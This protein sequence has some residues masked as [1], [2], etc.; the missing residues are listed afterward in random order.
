MAALNGH[1]M[2]QA[3]TLCGVDDA[4]LF[5]GETQ[6]QRIS[7]EVFDDDFVSCL[8]KTFSD[9]EDDWKTYSSLTVAQGQIRLRPGTKKNI[10]ALVQWAGDEIRLAR[11]PSSTAFP[12]GNVPVLLRRYHTHKNWA[13]K[14]D[15]K[16]KTAK[17]KQFSSKV[18]WEDWRDSLINFLRTQ[19]GRN[20]VPLSYVIR[21]SELAIIRQ[22]AEF[23]DDYVDHAFLDG[24]A[25]A[26]D[27]N[28][29]HTYIVNFITENETA[30][31][32]IL[33][34]LAQANGRV[35]FIALKEH[36]EGVGSNAKSV[37]R[38]EDDILQMF[39]MGEKKP[40][41]W[42][43]EFETRLSTGFAVIDK[44]EG[45]QVYSN[46]AK[47]RMLNR[48]VKADFL[49][50]AKTAIELEMNKVPMTI[51]YELALANYR[52]AVNKK[53]PPHE[54]QTRKARRIQQTNR[55]KTKNGSKNPGGN[56]NN[57]RKRSDAW[58]IT[59]DD[60][61][62]LEVHPSYSFSSDV[63]HKIPRDVKDRLMS[64]RQ[65]YK[66]RRE[67]NAVGTDNKNNGGDNGSIMGGRN[68]QEVLKSRNP[69]GRS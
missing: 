40:H 58:E 29:V 12:V 13:D 44:K 35:D 14:A 1:T 36:Y 52:N 18:K 53:F 46:G 7:N 23:L 9:L 68:E 11:D 21:E 56:K 47:L 45:Y 41:M 15:E 65:E 61:T 34:Y 55:N 32:K 42:W 27:A 39:Y 6:A 64:Q 67:A 8:D 54:S 26:S 28:E 66:K 43:E 16:A 5:E 69:H 22:N 20:G 33:P 10:K 38:A 31:N 49:Q 24:E 57:K 30:E 62:R 48:K 25:F 59:C 37:L 63:W 4:L 2:K 19:K 17:P 3:L 51:T 50:M 60:G